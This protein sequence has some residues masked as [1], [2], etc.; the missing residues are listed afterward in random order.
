MRV[1]NGELPDHAMLRA[2]TLACVRYCSRSSWLVRL[3]YMFIRYRQ[4]ESY[5][6]GRLNIELFSTSWRPRSV[7][8]VESRFCIPRQWCGKQRI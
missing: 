3:R 6:V 5:R 8:F 2:T 4:I 1:Q 7:L